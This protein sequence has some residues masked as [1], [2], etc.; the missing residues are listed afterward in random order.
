MTTLPLH[1]RDTFSNEFEKGMRRESD[2][3]NVC[4]RKLPIFL[5]GNHVA[6]DI[7]CW[8]VV[9]GSGRL[10]VLCWCRLKEEHNNGGWSGASC[11]CTQKNNTQWHLAHLNQQKRKDDYL[12]QKI[13]SKKKLL[14]ITDNCLTHFPK[15]TSA[16]AALAANSPVVMSFGLTIACSRTEKSRADPSRRMAAPSVRSSEGWPNLN[17]VPAHH[18][19]RW[20][21]F[22]SLR[23]LSLHRLALKAACD[24]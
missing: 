10:P 16:A 13:T 23:A 1:A 4:R 6:V 12:I 5:Q 14:L 18:L 9:Y 19:T 17:S 21:Q 15:S 11:K 7:C 2:S 8:E 3:G 22:H 20:P 24:D